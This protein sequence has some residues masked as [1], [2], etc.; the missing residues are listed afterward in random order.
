[1]PTIIRDPLDIPPRIG[2]GYPA[3]YDAPCLARRRHRLGDAAGLKNFGVNYTVLPPG[4]MSAQRHWHRVQD[5][6]V[7]VLS[8]ELVLVTDEGE[9]VLTP[10]MCAAFPAG[11]ENGHH[12]INRSDSDAAYLEIGDR[13]PG[14]SGE[15]PDVDMKFEFL[16]GVTVFTRKDGSAFP[17]KT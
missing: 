6:F 13:L 11:E 4:T 2:T 16:D 9:T 17:P 8:G 7:M 3:P 10:G 15:Y 14:D 5:E 1:M 12:L